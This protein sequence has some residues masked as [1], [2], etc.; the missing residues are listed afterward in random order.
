MRSRIHPFTLMLYALP[1][2][3]ACGQDHAPA[4]HAAPATEPAVPVAEQAV[5]SK[6]A[7]PR[8]PAPDGAKVFFITPADG[9]VVTGTFSV[10]FGVEGMAV[11]RA[12]D[13]TP[14]SGHHH[15]LIDTDLPDLALPI[16]ADAN[17]VHF[18]DGRTST[19]LTLP[20]GEHTLQLLFADHLHIPHDPPVYS[21]RISVRVE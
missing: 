12:G 14:A 9:A 8:T 1:L 4:E 13:N 18:G 6:P 2:L 10:E 5:D 21:E 15:L 16:P 17:H 19:E 20:A 7:M 11:V 3:A